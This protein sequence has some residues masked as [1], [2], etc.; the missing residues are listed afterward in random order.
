MPKSPRQV[1]TLTYAPIADGHS[2][3]FNGTSYMD[4]RSAL[5]K[6][7]GIFPIRLTKD[8]HL[9]MM[10]AMANAAGEGSVPYEKLAAALERFGG[11]EIRDS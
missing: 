7:F 4:V 10:R 5:F 6:T 8:D 9:D 3:P 1:D 11:I 2:L